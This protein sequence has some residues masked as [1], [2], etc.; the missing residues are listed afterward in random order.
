MRDWSNDLSHHEQT[1]YHLATSRSW[2]ERELVQWAHHEGLIQW[3]IT[4]W[5]D[6]LPLSYISL[7]AGT[8]ISSMSPPWGIDPMI[9]HTMSRHSTTQLHLT[10]GWNE[11]EFNEPT[12]RD[13]S[14][15]L[16]HHEQTLYH[17][18]TSHSWLERELVQWAHHEGLIQWSIT[19]WADTLPLS[20]ISL[21]AG[22]RI[23]S[24]SPPWGIDPMIYHTMSRHSTT[25]LHLAPGWNEN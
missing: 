11:N 15:D 9:Y 13:R 12:M 7:L 23:S 8:R 18:A 2:L 24:M 20:Y 4:P 21:L 25:Q 22:T 16:S 14:N 1:L 19:P 17:L 10:P 6:T 3:S 5:A